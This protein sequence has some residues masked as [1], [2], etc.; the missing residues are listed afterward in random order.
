MAAPIEAPDLGPW[1]D[2]ATAT[3]ADSVPSAAVLDARV[4]HLAGPP[5]LLGAAWTARAGRGG[6]EAVREALATAPA[7]SVLVIAGEGDLGHAVWGE[8]SSVVA[9]GRSA[10][11][12]LVDGAIRDLAAIRDGELAIFACGVTCSGPAQDVRGEVGVPIECA[13]ARVAPGDLVLGDADGVVVVPAASI[14]DGTALAT[15]AATRERARLAEV[16]AAAAGAASGVRGG[17]NAAATR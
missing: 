1:S 17:E 4:R 5:R 13:G 6:Y 7:G 15:S 8:I 14:A 9:R 12:V 2:L 10:A 3:V 16:T 11:G